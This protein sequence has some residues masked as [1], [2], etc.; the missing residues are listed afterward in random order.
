MSLPAIAAPRYQSE[1]SRFLTALAII[2]GVVGY[3]AAEIMAMAVVL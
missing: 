2:P 1:V 3:A